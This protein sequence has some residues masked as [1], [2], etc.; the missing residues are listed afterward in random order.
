MNVE[1]LL[2]E[3]RR[4]S[5]TLDRLVEWER[6]EAGRREGERYEQHTL[7]RAPNLFC[8][9][10]GGNASQ[11]R[12][13]RHITIWLKPYYDEQQAPEPMADPLL[14]DIIWWKGDEVVVAEVSHKV[15]GTEPSSR[16]QCQ[17]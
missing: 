7:R 9:G 17:K 2:E 16:Q 3:I 11:F 5:R 6:G 1:D 14:A 15:N 4:L 12:M 8:G 13:R 10:D